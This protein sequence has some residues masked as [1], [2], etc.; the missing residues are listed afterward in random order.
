MALP[1]TIISALEEEGIEL[2][3]RLVRSSGGEGKYFVPIF[4][5]TDS[6][7]HMRPGSRKLRQIRERFLA[8]G[9]NIEFLHYDRSLRRIEG[10]LRSTILQVHSRDVRNVFADATARN[11]RVFVDLK[12]PADEVPSQIVSMI[13]ALADQY[14]L[15]C[16]QVS[17]LNSLNV[18]TPFELLSI[19]RRLAPL[20]EKR[21]AAVL[22]QRGF[23]IPS[24][25]WLARRLDALRRSEQ[26]FRTK[27]K[28]YVLTL[29][30][31]LSLGSR[32]DRHSP[33]V[34]RMLALSRDGA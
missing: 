20:N 30:G 7:G 19:V 27:D 17:P 21:L 25:D 9:L 5:E 32:K 10:T 13:H 16:L 22:T 4:V 8:E 2:A 24:E 3:G 12:S 23:V 33:D 1:K 29:E 34:T 18:A 15:Q 14:Q 28:N 11:L 6:E 26:L 31:L